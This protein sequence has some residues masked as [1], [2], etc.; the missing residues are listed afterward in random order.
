MM[1][2]DHSQARDLFSHPLNRR[3]LLPI[4]SV[5]TF[6]C[7]QSFHIWEFLKERSSY[8]FLVHFLTR[9]LCT[10]IIFVANVQIATAVDRAP[11]VIRMS[12][13]DSEFFVK[14]TYRHISTNLN[15]RVHAISDGINGDLAEIDKLL[16]DPVLE[17]L[18][19]STQIEAI[20]E[21]ILNISTG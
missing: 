6:S 8:P 15:S 12:L 10:I 7:P 4:T 19:D 2:Q 21:N 11:N 20:F 17:E 5:A 1:P 3:S 16:G 14:D 13:K 18:A 9:S